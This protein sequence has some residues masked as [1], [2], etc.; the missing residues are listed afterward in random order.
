MSFSIGLTKGN[1]FIQRQAPPELQGNEGIK[2][3]ENARKVGAII[4]E[5][6]G[7]IWS[8]VLF[9]G[10]YQMKNLNSYSAAM[11]A[12]I[13][14][15]VPCNCCCIFGLPFGIWSLVVLN[16]PEVRDAFD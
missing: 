1:F 10:G 6:A 7:L 5:I 2:R 16:K 12:S 8:S 11:T 14:A 3:F 4:G 13:L 9:W 15:M